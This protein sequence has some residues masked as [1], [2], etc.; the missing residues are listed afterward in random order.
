MGISILQ[1]SISNSGLLI[2]TWRHETV[3]L[4]HW[5]QSN[6]AIAVAMLEAAHAPP[7][8]HDLAQGLYITTSRLTY[9]SPEQPCNR[10]IDL[11]R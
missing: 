2:R 5:N 6:K 4:R 7:D 8:L 11:E 1:R 3:D 9:A 10:A